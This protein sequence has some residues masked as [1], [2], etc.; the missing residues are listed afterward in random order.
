MM[1]SYKVLS[2]LL[3]YPRA[4]WL[5]HANDLKTVLAEEGL[6]P[7]KVRLPL[8]ALIDDMAGRDLLSVQ[9]DY[10]AL[11]DRGRGLSLYIF[12]HV[13]GESR[14]RGQAMVDLMSH[15]QARGFKITAAELPDY[16]PLF[17][18]FLSQCDP[19]EAKETLG[20]AVHIVAALGAKLAKRKSGYAA[21]FKAI[22]ALAVAEI[23]K[24]FVQRAVEEDALRDDSLEALDKE[25][26][27]VPAFDN[28]GT[29][30]CAVCPS[31]RP[32]LSAAR[33]DNHEI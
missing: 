28:T 26:E 22:E 10:V 12:E 19:E 23:D 6:L 16:L 15:Y 2:L 11:F 21:L 8:E 17:L 32:P 14:D 29:G 9:E 24:D 7:R 27:E 5:D 4:E 30:A 1:R 20:D 33:P 25:W 18:E 13:H 31:A 3:G